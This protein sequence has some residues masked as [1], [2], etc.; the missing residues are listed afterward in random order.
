MRPNVTD[1]WTEN[2]P[3]HQHT[4]THFFNYFTPH[5]SPLRSRK[6]GAA[7]FFAR[8]I[9]SWLTVPPSCFLFLFCFSCRSPTLSGS[10]LFPCNCFQPEPNDQIVRK[11][12]QR[13]AHLETL[14]S[15]WSVATLLTAQPC[16]RRSFHSLSVSSFSSLSCPS[17]ALNK[18]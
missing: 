5:F 6:L 4:N 13:S 16:K 14:S 15:K 10:T 11:D 9:R 3:R 2:T 7:L 1:T 18:L 12:G 17:D 8:S